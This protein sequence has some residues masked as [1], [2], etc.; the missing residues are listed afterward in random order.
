M[1][2]SQI[3]QN[4]MQAAA[5]AA[6]AAAVNNPQIPG[7]APP[8]TPPAMGGGMAASGSA[9]A[10]PTDQEAGCNSSNLNNAA[11]GRFNKTNLISK[12]KHLLVEGSILTSRSF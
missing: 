6:A 2:A 10:S 9:S 3:T 4:W 11:K 8:Q 1:E 5:A 7:S 12:K